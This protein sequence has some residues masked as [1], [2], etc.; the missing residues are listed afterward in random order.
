VQ[1]QSSTKRT[2]SRLQ[3]TNT[4]V[5]TQAIP[6]SERAAQAIFDITPAYGV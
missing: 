5:Y 4:R 2:Q 3:R 1:T 6:Q